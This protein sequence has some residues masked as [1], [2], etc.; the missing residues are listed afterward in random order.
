MKKFRILAAVIIVLC[1]IITTS[2][3]ASIP[4]TYAGT[5]EEPHLLGSPIYVDEIGNYITYENGYNVIEKFSDYLEA[6]ENGNITD[7][8]NETKTTFYGPFVV[9]RDFNSQTM[10]MA[11]VDTAGN[12]LYYYFGNG[13]AELVCIIPPVLYIDDIGNIRTIDYVG[14]EHTI[15]K[16]VNPPENYFNDNI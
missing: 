12:A 9:G 3:A 5:Y 16:A 2:T 7:M 13:T 15:F 14:R 4:T 6:D 11:V 10:T 1:G 8:M